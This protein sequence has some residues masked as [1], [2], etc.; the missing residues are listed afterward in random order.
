MHGLKEDA[1]LRFLVGRELIQLAL[2]RYEFQL[3]FDGEASSSVQC[4]LRLRSGAATKTIRSDHPQESKELACIVGEKVSGVSI[5]DQGALSIGFANGCE[6]ML[7][8]SNESFESYV[9]WN[10]GDFLVV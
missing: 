2:G 10:K 8:D 6:L 5:T 7:E 4:V 1:D 3:R 9:I